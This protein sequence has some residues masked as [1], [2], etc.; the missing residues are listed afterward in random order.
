MKIGKAA[1][2]DNIPAE[3]LKLDSSKAADMLLP[4]F[5]EICQKERFPKEWKEEIVIKIPKKGE[6]S[7]CNNWWC[8]TLL[9]VISK[10][11]YKIILDS[12]IQV[13]ALDNNVPEKQAVGSVQIDHI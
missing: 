3:I 6:L 2:S 1:G 13:F 7:L 10:I 12:I 5:Q 4:L 9:V 8:T 11:F